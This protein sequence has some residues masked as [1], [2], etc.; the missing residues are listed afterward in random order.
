MAQLQE[1]LHRGRVAV[2]IAG[3]MMRAGGL[4]MFNAGVEIGQLL[5]VSVVA[6]ALS[7]LRQRSETAGRRVAFAGSVVVI[8]AGAFWFI[9][10]VFFPGGIA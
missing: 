10:R 8:I 9:Q 2:A 6:T 3:S 4:R 7:A 5:V 1:E